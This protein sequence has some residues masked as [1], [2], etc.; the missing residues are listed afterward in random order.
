MSEGRRCLGTVEP[1][2]CG[3]REVVPP[4]DEERIR[5]HAHAVFDELHLSWQEQALV[6]GQLYGLSC[7]GV[8]RWMGWSVST[9]TTYRRNLYCRVGRHV[10]ELCWMTIDAFIQQIDS[11]RANSSPRD[12]GKA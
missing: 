1:V 12:G 11:G 5:H 7:S 3:G 8:A 6:I 10:N 4:L 9:V 2:R